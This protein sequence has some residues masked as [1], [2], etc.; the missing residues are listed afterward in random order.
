MSATLRISDDTES[1]FGRQVDI[2]KDTMVT[3]APRSFNSNGAVYIYK[4]VKFGEW[5]QAAV[6]DSQ[7]GYNSFF[8]NSVALY[9]TTLAVGA[10][11]YQAN[12]WWTAKNVDWSKN[13]E[14]TGWVYIYE[15]DINM[16]DGSKWDLVASL[17]SP[18]GMNSHFGQSVS[19]NSYYLGVGADGYPNGDCHGA[20]ILYKRV[21]KTDYNLTIAFPS[22]ADHNEYFGRALSVSDNY[23]LI[24]GA[25][26]FSQLR[27]ALYFMPLPKPQFIQGTGGGTSSIGAQPDSAGETAALSVIGI[28]IVML[29]LV[30]TVAAVAYSCG[31]NCCCVAIVPG[32]GKKKKKKEEEDSPYTVHSY[33][34]YSELDD[35]YSYNSSLPSMPYPPPPPPLPRPTSFMPPPPVKFLPGSDKEKEKL[36]AMEGSNQRVMLE[37]GTIVQATEE[38]IRQRFPYKVFSYRGYE[39]D[40]AAQQSQEREDRSIDEKIKNDELSRNTAANATGNAAISG[41]SVISSLGNR[42]NSMNSSFNTS[43][44]SASLYSMNS[45]ASS[46]YFGGSQ[47]IH[48]EE[49][50]MNGMRSQGSNYSMLSD[51]T[52]EH[53]TSMY[54]QSVQSFASQPYV[55]DRTRG[56]A[57]GLETVPEQSNESETHSSGGSVSSHAFKGILRNGPKVTAPRVQPMYLTSDT[58][59]SSSSHVFPHKLSSGEKTS[60]SSNKYYVSTEE[61]PGYE[62]QTSASYVQRAKAQYDALMRARTQSTSTSDTSQS[63]VPVYN[64]AADNVYSSD[65]SVSTANAPSTS[66]GSDSTGSYI[67]QA[68]AQYAALMTS[69]MVPSGQVATYDSSS[70][71]SSSFPVTPALDQSSDEQHDQDIVRLSARSAHANQPVMQATNLVD[72][73]RAKYSAAMAKLNFSSSSSDPV[74][75]QNIPGA[76]P[77]AEDASVLSDNKSQSTSSSSASFVDQARSK[78]AEFLMQRRQKHDTGSD[79]A[80]VGSGG[81]QASIVDQ[82]R[83]QYAEMISK[84]PTSSESSVSNDQQ[85]VSSQDSKPSI[86]DIA[87]SQYARVLASKQTTSISES[88]PL[89]QLNTADMLD[90]HTVVH[91]SSASSPDRGHDMGECLSPLRKAADVRTEEKEVDLPIPPSQPAAFSSSAGSLIEQTKARAAQALAQA[92]KLL[93]TDEQKAVKEDEARR[94]RLKE[95]ARIRAE[96]RARARF[97]MFKAKAEEHQ[98]LPEDVQSNSVLEEAKQTLAM[99]STPTRWPSEGNVVLPPVPPPVSM[100][101]TSSIVHTTTNVMN[102]TSVIS[103]TAV[104]SSK[105]TSR[106][107]LSAARAA[108]TDQRTIEQTSEEG[109]AGMESQVMEQSEMTTTTSTSR[110]SS[111]KTTSV[112]SS[113][114]TLHTAQSSSQKADQEGDVAEP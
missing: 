95:E 22:P 81:S 96:E 39:E 64:M 32:A 17:Q 37:D 28:L 61:S 23:N 29:L 26:A 85:S 42:S 109:M 55:G 50:V 65:S 107:A 48:G 18:L 41:A 98:S 79:T 90:E 63:G 62:S 21:S 84:R 78:Y 47:R 69:R 71:E 66:A 38:Y 43:L 11:G 67:D 105:T 80:S 51:Q 89:V 97:A 56:V 70:V 88:A 10:V 25:F 2:Y 77:D 6:L 30:V 58:E 59:Y 87:R 86:V 5:R 9:N 99:L 27:G 108:K 60:S 103:S 75:T 102:I 104:S 112:T 111:S 74:Q 15:M 12:I 73:A 49:S 16:P 46:D 44:H 100:A 53:N 35:N 54:S 3:G 92:R 113:T 72:Q 31:A 101:T 52:S 106:N 19:L 83:A 94:N 34:G 36:M 24:V 68:K 76:M 91:V 7:R 40:K 20:A 114:T 57:Y 4:R 1:A 45:D 8:G 93:L 13:P 82:A 14:N 33:V 110:T